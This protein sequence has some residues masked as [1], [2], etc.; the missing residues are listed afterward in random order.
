MET[1]NLKLETGNSQSP[2][3]FVDEAIDVLFDLSGQVGATIY[4][5]GDDKR[6]LDIHR[7]DFRAYLSNIRDQLFKTIGFLSDA[8]NETGDLKLET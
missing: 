4:L 8:K 7:R 6:L 3:T 2:R 5:M 1:R